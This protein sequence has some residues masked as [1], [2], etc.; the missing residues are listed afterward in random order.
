MLTQMTGQ[1]DPGIL[2]SA[3]SQILKFKKQTLMM[4]VFI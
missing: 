2:L 1:Q 4:R 3:P